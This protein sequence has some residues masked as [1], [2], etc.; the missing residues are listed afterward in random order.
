M[1]AGN[2]RPLLVFC[3]LFDDPH[4]GLPEILAQVFIREGGALSLR[5]GLRH[6]L[7]RKG[8]A[9]LSDFG[10]TSWTFDIH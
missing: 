3:R 4:G 2:E 8:L 9:R 10:A 1:P 6:R 7:A 5:M